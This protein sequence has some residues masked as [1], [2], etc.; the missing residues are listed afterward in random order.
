VSPPAS[1]PKRSPGPRA[2]LAL[3]VRGDLELA[4]GSARDALHPDLTPPP[5]IRQLA[6]G[7]LVSQL[8]P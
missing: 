2:A 7:D 4:D 8:R 3:L 5:S 1:A 6:A